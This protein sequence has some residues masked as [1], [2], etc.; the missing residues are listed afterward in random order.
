MAFFIL[1][2][3]ALLLTVWIRIDFSIAYSRHVRKAGLQS[4]P[5][6]KGDI[7]FF[8][9]GQEFYTRYFNDLKQA[10]TCIYA[11][12]YIIKNDE[13]ISQSFLKIL[14]QKAEDGVK[15]YLMLDRIG[16]AKAPKK[17]LKQIQAQGV[18]LAYS[19]NPKFPF[20]FFTLLARNHRKI[21]VI[22]HK[23]GYLG[24][25]NIGKEYIGKNPKLGY[26]RDYHLSFTGAGVQDL[27]EQFRKDWR[28]AGGS[29]LDK[30]KFPAGADGS[31]SYR[32]VSTYGKALDDQFLSFIHRAKKELIICSPYFIP[33]AKLQIELLRALERGVKVKIIV[34]MRSDHL[35]VKE[36]A[37]PYYGPLLKAGAEVYRFYLGFYHAKIIIVDDDFIDIGTANFDKRSMYLNDEMNALI[38]DKAF[39]AKV[40]RSIVK[41]IHD[42]EQLLYED[43]LQRP[44][45]QRAKEK[46]ASA[47]SFFL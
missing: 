34:P 21:T 26:W 41:D 40:K 17:L 6:R 25:Y 2:L 18:A 47:V 23:T 10:S 43:Y 29:Y 16:S 28:N 31:I 22:D 38:Q 19:H 4:Y 33:G 20:F 36:A 30:A 35:F 14:G 42:S 39:T 45:W 15:V 9:D 13:E 11:S 1:I 12:F 27:E 8:S 5:I 3:L 46:A 32:F 24:G 37:F 7:Q 44:L